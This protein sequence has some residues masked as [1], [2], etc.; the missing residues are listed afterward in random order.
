MNANMK[1]PAGGG[2]PAAGHANERDSGRPQLSLQ[3]LQVIEGE[4][5]AG[6]YLARLRA[7]QTSPDELALILAMLYGETFLG[8]CRAIE[9]ELG[10][11]HA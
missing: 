6:D 7:Q 9:K 10:G 8:F 11:R 1:K 4:R 5:K 2:N 3:A